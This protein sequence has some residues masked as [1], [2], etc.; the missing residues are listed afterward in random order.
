[1]SYI[2]SED[3]IWKSLQWIKIEVAAQ[4]INAIKVNTYKDLQRS[5]SNGM[6]AAT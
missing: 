3:M 4:E 1:M 5:N 2:M 6:N